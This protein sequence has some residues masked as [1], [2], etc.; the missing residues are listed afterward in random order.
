MVGRAGTHD[1]AGWNRVGGLARSRRTRAL[2]TSRAILPGG[3]VMTSR[4]FVPAVLA[5]FVLGTI[6]LLGA[7]A[8]SAG[9]QC[10][11]HVFDGQA[12]FDF[13]GW[14]VDGGGDVDGDGRPD[15]IVGALGYMS[16]GRAEVYSGKTG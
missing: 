14:S 9:A 4:S 15:V 13:L 11:V 1:E 10:A 12:S 16:G 6:A 3:V 7:T 2:P 8:A 5:R